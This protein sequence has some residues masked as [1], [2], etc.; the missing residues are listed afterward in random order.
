M[1]TISVT[2]I[3][4]RGVAVAPISANAGGDKSLTPTGAL[5]VFYNSDSA[6][7]TVTLTTPST[8]KADG[9][10]GVSNPPPLTIAAGSFGFIPLPD[11]FSNSSDSNLAAW[12]YDAVTGV[13]A[14]VV[15]MA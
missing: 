2:S 4:R 11:F 14:T 13:K 3:P 15:R 5:A 9:D 10:L 12:G 8:R 7:H 1:A 6:S